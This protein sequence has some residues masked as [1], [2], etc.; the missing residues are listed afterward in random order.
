MAFIH[1]ASLRVMAAVAGLRA[2]LADE[3]G[4]DL[5]EYGL[6]TGL[7]G[8]AIVGGFLLFP[9]A[10]GVMTGFIAE[11]ISFSGDCGPA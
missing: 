5:V 6:L 10:I 7:I 3:R 4:Q 11:C 1:T 9:A 8:V 2:R